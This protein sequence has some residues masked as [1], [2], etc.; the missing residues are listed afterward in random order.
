MRERSRQ[1]A[2]TSDDVWITASG[3]RLDTPE[4]LLAFLRDYDTHSERPRSL[5]QVRLELVASTTSGVVAS[6]ARW[7]VRQNGAVNFS[8]GDT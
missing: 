6:C 7:R 8:A 3:E 1:H 5:R 4:K 2:S